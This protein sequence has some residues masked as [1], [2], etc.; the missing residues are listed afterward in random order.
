MVKVFV[1]IVALVCACA[2]LEP[3]I[4]EAVIKD[5]LAEI[6]PGWEEER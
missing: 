5:R 2:P 6:K 4:P 1:L 3:T